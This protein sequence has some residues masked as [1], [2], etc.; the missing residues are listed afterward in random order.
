MCKATFGAL[1]LPVE[2]VK[3]VK[4]VSIKARSMVLAAV[5]CL[6]LAIATGVAIAVLPG[7]ITL[8]TTASLCGLAI[9]WAIDSIWVEKRVDIL[10]PAPVFLAAYW[11]FYGAGSASAPSQLWGIYF[12]GSITFLLGVLLAKK[13]WE[14][15]SRSPW[16]R[17]S[18]NKILEVPNSNRLWFVTMIL[19]GIGSTGAV[20]TAQWGGA[21]NLLSNVARMAA[22]VSTPVYMPYLFALL[23][24]AGV[25]VVVDLFAR[26]D[27]ERKRW[28]IFR[29][30]LVTAFI[31]GCLIVYLGARAFLVPLGMG[32]LLSFH[33]FYKRLGLREF[34]L[35][36]A[37]AI[38]V[39][40]LWY[41]ARHY[42]PMI[43]EGDYA[44]D[45]QATY[46]PLYDQSSHAVDRLAKL[47]DLFPNT[48]SFWF[49]GVFFSQLITLLPGHQWL[50]DDWITVYILGREV[51]SVGGS[52]PTIL[53]GFY[54]DGGMPAVAVGMFIIGVAIQVM[55]LAFQRK[56]TPLRLMYYSYLLSFICVSVYGFVYLSTVLLWKCAVLFVVW[57]LACTKKT[58]MLS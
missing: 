31:C 1:S 11:I 53:G 24:V 33:H 17:I 7:E 48:H 42:G 5:S 54:M 4:T 15:P 45:M 35:A 26:P 13:L 19:L 37:I 46:V 47:V 50:V 58:R 41:S 57:R 12:L 39:M 3:K 18:K 36:F 56:P 49:G 44:L 43:I 28:Y 40:S 30:L 29:S 22:K 21:S 20:L 16:E 27:T 10:S 14:H 52:P 34:F 55:Y 25:I 9:L 2:R 8:I 6:V 51:T 38:L 23:E 32:A